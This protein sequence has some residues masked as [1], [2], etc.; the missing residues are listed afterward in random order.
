[1]IIKTYADFLIEYDYLSKKLVTS[2]VK[3]SLP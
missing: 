2:M 3:F 1:M